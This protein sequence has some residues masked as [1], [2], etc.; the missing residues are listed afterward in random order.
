[1]RTTISCLLSRL[2]L[3]K[4][5]QVRTT[6]GSCV[7]SSRVPRYYGIR[8]PEFPVQ[9]TTA[10]RVS[11]C[12]DCECTISTL[13]WLHR[14]DPAHLTGDNMR[15]GLSDDIISRDLN[16]PIRER[17]FLLAP[18][19]W[20]RLLSI[21]RQALKAPGDRHGDERRTSW[22]GIHCPGCAKC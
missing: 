12:S 9:L 15:K 21:P 5:T 10:R 17:F 13:V 2:C 11:S 20:P 18:T 14:E 7:K 19:S 6:P 1:M 16:A 4:P 3:P 22:I 8:R